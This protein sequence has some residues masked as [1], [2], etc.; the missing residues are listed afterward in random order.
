[1][2]LILRHDPAK[3]GLT[4]DENGWV[5]VDDLLQGL[6]RAGKSVTRAELDYVVETND[7]KRF[8][9][10][11]DGTKIRASQGH[12]VDVDL[13]IKPQAP[14]AILYHGTA[15]RFLDSIL[16]QGLTK[17]SRQHVHLS[18]D[19][20]TASKVGKRHGKLAILKVD[21]KGMTAQG[22]N[23]YLSQNGVWLTEKVPAG[24]LSLSEE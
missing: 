22:E 24:F 13:A 20:D 7:K 12:S 21:A 8:A 23:F 14:P 17:Q 1:M 15:T 5:S 16:S 18:A 19:L 6:S 2:S 9:Y 4:L 11:E 10:S 3:A